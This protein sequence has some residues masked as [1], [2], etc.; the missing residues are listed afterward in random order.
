MSLGIGPASATIMSVD[1][2]AEEGVGQA[3]R[4]KTMTAMLDVRAVVF[5]SQV[6]WK[7]KGT[8]LV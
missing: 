5:V 2:A 1:R 6:A 4:L 7:K 3:V 8:Q